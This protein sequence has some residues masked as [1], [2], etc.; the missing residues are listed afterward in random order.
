MFENADDILEH[1]GIRG[2]K[3][4]VR[5]RRGADGRVGGGISNTS[6][7][8]KKEKGK[9]GATIVI[10]RK[11]AQKR[12]PLADV[13][14]ETLK[15]AVERMELEKRYNTLSAEQAQRSKTRGEKFMGEVVKV[16]GS[17]AKSQGQRAVNAYVGHAVDEQL[18]KAG[19]TPK[20]KKKNK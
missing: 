16:G 14:S 20:K 12:N 8:A 3:W 15:K 19:I 6:S 17:I 10:G 5:R 13:D 18:K 9:K 11:K 4:G 7:S 2:M 1:Y